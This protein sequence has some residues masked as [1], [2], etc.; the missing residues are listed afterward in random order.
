MHE[1]GAFHV[2]A[3]PGKTTLRPDAALRP[4]LVG[5]PAPSPASASPAQGVPLFDHPGA[6]GADTADERPVGPTAFDTGVHGRVTRAATA[7]EWDAWRDEVVTRRPPAGPVGINLAH[8]SLFAAAVSPRTG[9][10]ATR[11]RVLALVAKVCEVA[12]HPVFVLLDAHQLSP[13]GLDPTAGLVL[14]EDLFARGVQAVY[15]GVEPFGFA[16]LGPDAALAAAMRLQDRAGRA[17]GVQVPG[18]GPAHVDA[19]RAAGFV[20]LVGGQP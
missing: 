19:A 5:E 10:P 1:P 6:R 16:P 17:L 15:A 11:A 3:W 2:Y 12:P 18:A 9:T 20:G 8:R 7:A 4:V 14:V 13:F